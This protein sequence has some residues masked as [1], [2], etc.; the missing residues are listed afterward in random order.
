MTVSHILKA[1]GGGV[2]SAAPSAKV[3]DIAKILSENRIGA[4]VIIGAVTTLGT[5]LRTTF[6]TVGASI[7]GAR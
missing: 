7:A 1:K 4:V 6:S 5:N 3:S 2:I